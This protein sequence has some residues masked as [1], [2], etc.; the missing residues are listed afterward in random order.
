MWCS[1]SA[2]NCTAIQIRPHRDSP[3]RDVKIMNTLAVH[4]P[5]MARIGVMKR[6]AL[7][8]V[9]KNNIRKNKLTSGKLSS[10]ASSPSWIVKYPSCE[11]AIVPP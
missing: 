8:S 11:H 7:F 5:A 6:S 10:L 1:K 4:T 3:Q 2:P 9:T